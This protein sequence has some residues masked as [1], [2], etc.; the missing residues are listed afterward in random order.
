MSFEIMEHERDI[1]TAGG[2]VHLTIRVSTTSIALGGPRV[3]LAAL[4]EA[5]KRAANENLGV[6]E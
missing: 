6:R 1:H 2:S 4:V 5:I 3:D